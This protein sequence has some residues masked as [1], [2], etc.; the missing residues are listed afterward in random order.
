[1]NVAKVEGGWVADKLAIT[2]KKKKNIG[3]VK[4]KPGIMA[5]NKMK[6]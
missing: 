2:E 3:V 5:W 6:G 1:M 4:E